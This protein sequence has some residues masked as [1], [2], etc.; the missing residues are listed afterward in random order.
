M[1]SACAL[2]AVVATPDN[3]RRERDVSRGRNIDETHHPVTQPTVT[4]R[5]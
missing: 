5:N 1:F 2:T 3:E 4:V